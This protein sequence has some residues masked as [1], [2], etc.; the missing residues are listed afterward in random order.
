MRQVRIF[1][2]EQKNQSEGDRLLSRT[3]YFVSH[4]I[5]KGATVRQVIDSI[6]ATNTARWTMWNDSLFDRLI[7]EVDNRPM[8][9]PDQGIIWQEELMTN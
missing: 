7:V 2:G 3:R 6:E 1:K 4:D 9:K 5:L 8:D